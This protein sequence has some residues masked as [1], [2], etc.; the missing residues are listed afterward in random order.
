MDPRPPAPPAA[1]SAPP[2]PPARP[3][4][5]PVALHAPATAAEPAGSAP[6]NPD[7]WTSRRL[8]GWIADAFTKRDLDA[9]RLSAEI[10]LA[11][12]LCT[13]RLRLY[14]DPD[15]EAT[16]EELAKLRGLVGRAL[17]H[18][19][20]QYLVGEGWFFGLPF[21][22][23]R[24]VLV[25]RPCTELIVE[26]V[27]QD[28]RARTAA[29]GPGAALPAASEGAAATE[30]PAAGPRVVA[31]REPEILASKLGPKAGPAYGAGMTLVDVC[32][33]SGCIAVALAKNL[34]GLRV[35]GSDL[36]ADALA[37]AAGNAER[38]AVAGRIS[39]LEGDGCGPALESLGAASADYV[40]ANPPYI[41]DGEWDAVP[42]NVREHEPAMA[43][44]GGPDGLDVVRPVIE[45]AAALLKPGGLLLVECAASN[46]A[47]AAE[48]T[49][50][51]GR[52]VGVLVLE[53][54]EGLPRAVLAR[55]AG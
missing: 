39:W 27:I 32:T 14:T 37:A 19:P 48:F 1:R 35:V 26:R 5:R 45:G 18:E 7:A 30:A 38:H 29:A 41:P 10:L 20:V 50:G 13:Q 53:D 28:V 52:F 51:L 54:L 12:V 6:P 23:D 3:I 25:P 17:K 22:V 15:R 9:P 55:R 46:A 8:L 36:S 11:D 24:R 49:R 4:A 40:V 42:A 34:P 43:L 2:A 33:G 44:R 21:Y 47:A 31:Q 16:P